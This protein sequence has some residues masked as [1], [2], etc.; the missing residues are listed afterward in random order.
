MKNEKLLSFEIE[1]ETPD[2]YIKIKEFE[3]FEIFIE[4]LT[5][6]QRVSFHDRRQLE[7][8]AFQVPKLLKKIRK[9]MEKPA[10]DNPHQPKLF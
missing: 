2:N 8:L 7:F 9:S 3:T 4:E 6:S 1:T 10:E 5:D